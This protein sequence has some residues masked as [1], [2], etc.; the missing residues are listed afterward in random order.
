MDV[1]KIL[2]LFMNELVCDIDFLRKKIKFENI[3]CENILQDF[4]NLNKVVFVN[5]NFNFSIGN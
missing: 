4:I 3:L 2:D 1:L 5:C